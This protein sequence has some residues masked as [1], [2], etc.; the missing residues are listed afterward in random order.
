MI[1]S[2]KASVD[3]AIPFNICILSSCI[4]LFI[5]SNFTVAMEKEYVDLKG[6]V[7]ND[8]LDEATFDLLDSLDNEIALL[9]KKCITVMKIV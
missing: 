7:S 6:I 8:Y 4:D 9:V 5:H 3:T 2:K 1:N